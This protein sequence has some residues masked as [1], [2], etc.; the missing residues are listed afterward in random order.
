MLPSESLSDHDINNENY[1]IAN[2]YGPN[3]DDPNFFQDVIKQIDS[4]N[5][6]LKII[7]GDLN[8][9]LETIDKTGG[10]PRT[11]PNARDVL[12]PY[13]NDANLLD[14]WRF[15]NPDIQDRGPGFWKSN[16]SLLEDKEF[17]EQLW[18][19]IDIELEQTYNSPITKWELT[20]L[21]IRNYTLKQSAIKKKVTENKLSVLEWK[22]EEDNLHVYVLFYDKEQHIRAPKVEI[23]EILE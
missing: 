19:V 21:A 22:L 3:V 23:D 8:L 10:T 5:T 11:H 4:M 20:K 12:R 14:V 1:V 13:I 17:S 16:T 18:R 9:Y 2:I 6:D 7:A 15:M